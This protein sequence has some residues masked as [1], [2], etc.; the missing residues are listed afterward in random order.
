VSEHDEQVT[1]I[2]WAETFKKQYPGVELLHAIPNGG[3]RNII[4][5]KKLKAEGVKAGVPDL[6]L[7]VAKRGYHGLYIEMKRPIV[8][9][10]SKP[11][12]TPAQRLWLERLDGQGY[13]ACVCYGAGTAIERLEKYMRAEIEEH[14]IPVKNVP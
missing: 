12:V 11:V 4:V 13:Y 14:E 5:A 1:V 8:K 10:K 3:D 9:G 2:K 6:F 7:P